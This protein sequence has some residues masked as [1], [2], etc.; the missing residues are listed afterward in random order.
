VK[1]RRV[2]LYAGLLVVV[3]TY[4][5]RFVEGIAVSD[6]LEWGLIHTANR[7]YAEAVPFLDRAAVGEVRLRALRM[8]GEGRLYAWERRVR[9]RGPLAVTH[10]LLAGAAAN[11]LQCRC[12]G[13][14]SRRSWEGLGEVYDAAE[15]IGRERRSE[16]PIVADADPWMR[17]G[18]PG[19][20]AVG[21]MRKAREMAPTW[22]RVHN[23]LALALWAYGLEAEARQAVRDSARALPLFSAHYYR[24]IAQVPPWVLDE[25]ASASWEALGQTPLLPRTIQLIDLGKLERRRGDDVRAVE[26]LRGALSGPG[27]ALNR[28]EASYHL[29]LALIALGEA[30][31]GLRRLKDAGEHPA[32][33]DAALRSLAVS[34]DHLGRPAEALDHLR[35]LRWRA[36]DDVWACL[37]Y[38]A[39]ARKLGDPSAAIEA[40]EWAMGRHPE[41]PAP[42]A[43]LIDLHI[44]QRQWVQAATLLDDLARR[45]DAEQEVARLRKVL[46]LARA[47]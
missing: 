39:V 43:A 3:G 11:F 12:A 10:E 7:D 5:W 13:P 26:A 27:E 21:L 36:P 16:R 20:V 45:S 34:L 14:A 47:Q 8:A 6:A 40:L 18:R 31:E 19:R 44:V 1:I 17:V 32:F 4:G 37:Q 25:F 2:L 28:A 24:E 41:D 30:E 46:A 33:H 42:R 35:K 29:G 15:W 22:F 38:A 23:K 9:H